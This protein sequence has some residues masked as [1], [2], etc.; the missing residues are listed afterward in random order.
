M[1]KESMMTYL[2][3]SETRR[4]C[5]IFT[6]LIQSKNFTNKDVED[7]FVIKV[8]DEII[9][10]KTGV[11]HFVLEKNTEVFRAR[12]IDNDDLNTNK[13]GISADYLD[14]GSFYST[15][16]DKYGSKEAPIGIPPAARNNIAGMS[17][18]YL[19]EDPYTACAEIRPINCSYVSLATFQAKK[20]IHL[21][22]FVHHNTDISKYLPLEE[23]IKALPNGL[24]VSLS[25]LF[26][27]LMGIFYRSVD[28]EKPENYIASQIISDYIRKT[29]LDGIR[30]LSSMSGGTNIT[31]FNSH[32]SIIAF[33]SSKLVY[34]PSQKFDIIDLNSGGKILPEDSFVTWKDENLK[35][36]RD[37][38]VV[39]VKHNT[40]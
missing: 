3:Q 27:W 21:L 40:K 33:K 22:N 7:S 30:Y 31:I 19:A 12:I 20:D 10:D 6:E 14:D 18:L 2:Q 5:Y 23:R 37:Q 25:E 1:D 11:F 16:F 36:V 15:G 8:L 34:V 32:E 24:N 39:S 35:N 9:A 26:T 38:I 29:G 4:A 13:T 17:Y 28:V